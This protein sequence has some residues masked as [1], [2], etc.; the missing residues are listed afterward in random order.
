MP[1]EGAKQLIKVIKD[2]GVLHYLHNSGHQIPLESPHL[3]SS[4][5]LNLKQKKT[6]QNK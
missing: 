2:R 5:I 3:L 6:I 4:H 1:D